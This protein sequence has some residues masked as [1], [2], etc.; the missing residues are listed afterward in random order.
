[1]P[2]ESGQQQKRLDIAYFE[3]T[4]SLVSHTIAKKTEFYH[5]E[6][7]RSKTIGSIEKREGQ[8][9]LGTNSSNKP[10]VTTQNDGLFA[11]LHNQTNSLYRISAN[12]NS[13]L[14][15]NVKDV[16]LCGDSPAIFNTTLPTYSVGVS[17]SVSVSEN[18]LGTLDNFNFYLGS[19][20]TIY[21]LNASNQWIPL[22][23]SGTN[24]L[25]GSFDHTYAEGNVFLVNRNSQ[26]RYIKADG[27]TVITSTEGSGHVFNT[28]PASKVNFY[29][30]RL[31]LA[32]FT[33]SGVRYPTTILRSSFPMGIVALVNADYAAATPTTIKITDNKYFYTDSGANSYEIYRGPN[34]ITTITVTGINET[35]ITVT[36]T[37]TGVLASDEIWITG[38]YTGSKIF[39]W[40][41]N[42]SISGRDFKQYDTFKLS[43][44][45]SDPVTMM[46]NIGNIMLLANKTSMSSWNDYVLESFDMNVGCVSKKGYI[47]NL[48]ILYFLHYTGIYQTT[49]GVPTLISNKIER[50]INGATTDG[51]EASAAGS[52]GRSVFFTLGDVTLY[53]PDGSLEKILRDVCI[54]FNIVQQNFFIHTN[55]KASEF[56]TFVET[57]NSDR[58]EFT[59]TSGNKSVKEFLSSELDDGKE[60]SMRID[61]QKLTMQPS[62]ENVNNLISILVDV[63]RGA[64]GQ[65][66]LNLDNQEEY[67]PLEG[68]LKKGLS[69]IKITNKD[70]DRGKPPI[71]RLVS[72]SIRDSSRQIFKCSRLSLIYSTTNNDVP[73]N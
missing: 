13:T 31:Y 73:D 22:T 7:A 51:K 60:I 68:E 47:K 53:K 1:M 15:I 18:I 66:F 61:T 44:G 2:Q 23:G 37:I 25:G 64:A 3:G 41:N 65:V 45:E 16:L 38:T 62:F 21:S 48:G 52:K 19:N 33:Q 39:R 14:S 55:V 70:E 59:D 9:V 26:N 4:N 28:P 46:T 63:D 35:D 5:T 69:N 58:C 20:V 42:P 71:T 56:E 57:S 49:G 11:F 50:Y 34:K 27:T 10:F 12:E 40:V 67:F 32:D 6:N 36:G 17:D 43:G 30:N 29:K 8:V 54:E 24:I 72:V